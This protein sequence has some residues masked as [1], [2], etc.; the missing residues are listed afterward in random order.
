[1]QR[2]LSCE[3]LWL[4]LAHRELMSEFALSKL[5]Y[6]M[7]ERYGVWKWS[8]TN[9]CAD[10]WKRLCR[11]N[12]IEGIMRERLCSGRA[13]LSSIEKWQMTET[14]RRELLSVVANPH[15][16][17][18]PISAWMTSPLTLTSSTSY[19]YRS[20]FQRPASYSP[21]V[22]DVRPHARISPIVIEL[23]FIYVSR[24]T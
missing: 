21:S 13:G 5:R 3:E 6:C 17:G 4:W 18:R 19:Y 16:V 9:Y 24:K 11:A 22:A 12:G 2:R 1:M 10:C 8:A 20:V 15:R 14:P 7:S 23:Q